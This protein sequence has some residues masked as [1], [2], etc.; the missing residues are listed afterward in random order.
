MARIDISYAKSLYFC[1]VKNHERHEVAAEC[2]VF[3]ACILLVNSYPNECGRS[4]TRKGSARDTLTARIGV[5]I[6][7][8]SK[9]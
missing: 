3:R 7:L 9:L 5:F 4:N 1:G 8:N 2:S 6:C